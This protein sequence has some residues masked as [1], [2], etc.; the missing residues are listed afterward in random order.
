L[1]AKI[2][3]MSGDEFSKIKQI[4][5]LVASAVPKYKVIKPDGHQNFEETLKNQAGQCWEKN[6]LFVHLINR[7]GIEA[8]LLLPSKSLMGPHA[9]SRVFLKE[10]IL[11]LDVTDSVPFTLISSA[12]NKR[13]CQTVWDF[14]IDELAKGAHELLK[15][16]DAYQDESFI[17]EVSSNSPKEIIE[18]VAAQNYIISEELVKILQQLE[19]LKPHPLYELLKKDFIT[20]ENAGQYA[21]KLYP[22]NIKQ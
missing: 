9:Y 22:N 17:L 7:A 8:G 3:A 11:D 4:Y 20:P 2:D 10:G 19:N 14:E 21:E 15:K 1:Y 18:F 6:N 12:I 13:F 16:P 5:D